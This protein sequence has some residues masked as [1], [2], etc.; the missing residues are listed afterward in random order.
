MIVHNSDQLLEIKIN[1]LTTFYCL[2]LTKTDMVPC[3]T[4]I[5]QVHRLLLVL[6]ALEFLGWM[7]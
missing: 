6:P 7:Q 2:L 1:Y 4:V 3:P 5:D